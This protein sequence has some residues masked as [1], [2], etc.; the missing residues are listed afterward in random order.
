METDVGMNKVR[1]LVIALL[2]WGMAALILQIY[3]VNGYGYNPEP[4]VTNI[5]Y[6]SGLFGFA[7]WGAARLAEHEL[8]FPLFW[9]LAG[10][11]A[12][13]LLP[14]FACVSMVTVF[15]LF[16]GW[17]ISGEHEEYHLPFVPASL[18]SGFA[19]L[20]AT[21]PAKFF[22]IGQD[23][24]VLVPL[25]A[26]IVFATVAIVCAYGHAPADPASAQGQKSGSGS[27]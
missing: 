4:V 15:A 16:I 1:R 5:A 24:N 27:S 7:F 25:L 8:A 19:M 17:I 21:V 11:S 12:G 18:A 6:A 3:L 20:A 14:L 26:L 23:E 9:G 10:I 2:G 13:I 22:L